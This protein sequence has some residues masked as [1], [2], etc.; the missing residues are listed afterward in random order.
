VFFFAEP[1]QQQYTHEHNQ[2]HQQS[3]ATAENAEMGYGNE[4]QS[5]WLSCLGG[6]LPD[7]YIFP[8]SDN[9]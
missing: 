7:R 3:T 9:Q 1:Q 6:Y 8:A 5:S 4:S 2:Q